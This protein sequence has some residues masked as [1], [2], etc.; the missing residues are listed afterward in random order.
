MKCQKKAYMYNASRPGAVFLQFGY[1]KFIAGQF[2]QIPYKTTVLKCINILK[3]I[4]SIPTGS[5]GCSAIRIIPSRISRGLTDEPGTVR[6]AGLSLSVA[7]LLPR[8]ADELWSL[9]PRGQS[10]F[11]DC[12][13]LHLD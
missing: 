10:H 9:Q 7:C 5:N 3:P 1:M 13:L 11:Y 12:L 8:H 4:S 2:P 6:L